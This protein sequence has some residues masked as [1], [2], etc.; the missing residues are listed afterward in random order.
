M[1]KCQ[2]S[3]LGGLSR[4]LGKLSRFVGRLYRRRIRSCTGHICAKQRLRR[5]RPYNWLRTQPPIGRLYH[6]RPYR[7]TDTT[8]FQH[9]C[10]LDTGL[11]IGCKLPHR[12]RTRPCT[13]GYKCRRS[14]KGWRLL[15]STR[16]M[17]LCLSGTACRAGRRRCKSCRLG[18]T[19]RLGRWSGSRLNR[20]R[21]LC[22]S[23]GSWC[24][25]SMLSG[26]RG[27]GPLTRSR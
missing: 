17:L 15:H 16:C 27:R 1:D 10:R 9:H 22:W 11:C 18:L 26:T 4:R 19:H 24:K 23:D 7:T 21:A 20:S 13:L 2:C 12:P 6:P 3:R 8:R 5:R 25:S 14:G